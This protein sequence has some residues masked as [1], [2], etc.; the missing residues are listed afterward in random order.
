ME[1][2]SD[3]LILPALFLGALGFFV[4]RLLGR[5]LP[6]GV[7]PLLLNGFL[8]TLMLIVCASLGFFA[9]YIWQGAPASELVSE[10]I[11]A[12]VRQFGRLGL[13]SG[14]I[15][16]PVMILS[17]SGLPKHWTEKTW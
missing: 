12:A 14:L 5:L 4:P 7:G 11:G 17:L 13:I 16:V 2:I 15:W 1:I 6:E 8:S 9:L 10:G 3:G